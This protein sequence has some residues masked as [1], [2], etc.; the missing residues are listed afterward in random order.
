[1]VIKQN[2]HTHTHLKHHLMKVSQYRSE[3]I[4][5]FLF[6]YSHHNYRIYPLLFHNFHV[7]FE[8]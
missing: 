5:S 3:L 7:I 2:T 8:T 4:Q 1:M 6:I